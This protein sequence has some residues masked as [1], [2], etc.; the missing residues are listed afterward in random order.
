MLKYFFVEIRI[1]FSRVVKCALWVRAH[2]N[3]FVSKPKCIYL[4]I[5][6]IFISLDT[7]LTIV[8]YINRGDNNSA[9]IGYFERFV[10]PPPNPT[11]SEKKFFPR[12]VQYFAYKNFLDV[13]MKFALNTFLGATLMYSQFL[14]HAH[15][16]GKNKRF[17]AKIVNFLKCAE[18]CLMCAQHKIFLSHFEVY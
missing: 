9:K 2:K 11:K 7:E 16:A 13:C 3:F 15:F 12:G 10:A 18:M 8:K 4:K 5:F 1:S 17:S 14:R 6:C